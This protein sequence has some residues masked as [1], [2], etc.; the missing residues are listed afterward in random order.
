MAISAL[1]VGTNLKHEYILDF[2]STLT[3]EFQ[4]K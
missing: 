2:C 1:D 4:T 3:T